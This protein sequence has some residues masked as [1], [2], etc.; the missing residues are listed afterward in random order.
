MHEITIVQNLLEVM[1]AEAAKQKAKPVW[2]KISCGVF[3]AVNDEAL[4]F[5][6]EAVSKGTV[7]EGVK[8]EIVHKP[9]QGKCRNCGEDFVIDQTSIKCPKCGSEDFELL[10]EASLLLEE[11]EFGRETRNEG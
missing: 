3:D 1:L 2:A 6:F 9:I 8:L 10:P 4:C 7:C 5:A 11:I